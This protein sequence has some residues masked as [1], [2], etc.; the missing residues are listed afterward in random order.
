MKYVIK[1]PGRTGAHLIADFIRRAPGMQFEYIENNTDNDWIDTV[2]NSVLFDHSMASPSDPSEYTLVISKRRNKRLHLLSQLVA[3]ITNKYRSKADKPKEPVDQS[4]LPHLRVL[5]KFLKA[6]LDYI[7]TLKELPWA[8]VHEVYFEDFLTN[9]N[10]LCTIVDYEH[11]PDWHH[12]DNEKAISYKD[13]FANPQE[14]MFLA[15]YICNEE[16]LQDE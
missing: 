11:K 8:K 3:G 15:R 7:S 5:A 1:A 16:Y 14:I 9:P 12:M 4:Y 6:R 13:V 10:V 2:D